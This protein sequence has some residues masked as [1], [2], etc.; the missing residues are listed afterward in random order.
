MERFE[1]RAAAAQTS[2][3]PVFTSPP[4]G[5]SPVVSPAPS[6]TPGGVP[7]SHRAV[8]MMDSAGR[9]AM[10]RPARGSGACARD[11]SRLMGEDA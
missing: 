6:K 9:Q 11:V 7:V 4:I 2:D 8:G 5:T 10:G 3:D 1:Y